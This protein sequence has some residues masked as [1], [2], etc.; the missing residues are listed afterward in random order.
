MHSCLCTGIET[1][2]HKN[3]QFAVHIDNG[4]KYLYPSDYGTKM[5]QAWDL[6]R[7]PFCADATGTK[8]PDA[9]PWCKE[10]WCYVNKTECRL[11]DVVQGGGFLQGSPDD[12]YYSYSACG[13]ANLFQAGDQNQ[14]LGMHLCMFT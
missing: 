3:E 10:R 7:E 8:R 4:K 14:R 5:C 12:L 6:E 11:K 2:S 1:V 13:S 9:K